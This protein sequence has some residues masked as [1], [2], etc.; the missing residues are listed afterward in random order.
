MLID[1]NLNLS[2]EARRERLFAGHIVIDPA[3][4]AMTALVDH[5]RGI[6]RETFG[7]LDPERAQTTMPVEEYVEKIGPMK[8]RF[9]ND[10]RTKV[11]VREVLTEAGCDLKSTYFDVPRLRVATFDQYL[12]A[13]VGYAYKAHRDSWYA[14]PDCQ[15]NWWVPVFDLEA[16]RSLAFYPKYWN[17]PIAN[18][19]ADFDYDEWCA[20]GRPGAIKQIKTDTRKHPLPLEP[21]SIEDEF[22]PSCPAGTL[23]AFAGSHLHASVPNTTQRTR[24][25]F[26]FRTVNAEDLLN[27]VGAPYTDNRSTGTT[28]GDFLRAHDLSPIG[29]ELVTRVR[30]AA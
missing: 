7:E 18:S 9:T 19:S 26:D 29:N 20:V 5:A 17:R 14:S 12:T 15:V 30:R 23:V 1:F 24:F 28:L 22:R 11:L 4:P 21:L 27:G 2:D 13:G 16:D 6:I 10:A 8:S 3:T 25:S